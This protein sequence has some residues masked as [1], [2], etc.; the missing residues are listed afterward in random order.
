MAPSACVDFHPF[1]ETL[2]EWEKG[3]PVDCG[4]DWAWSTI[5]AAVEKG[6]HKSATTPESVA[7]IA[8]DVAYQ[9][10]AGYAQVITWAE[11]QRL[12]PPNLKVSPLA[13]V[14]QRNRRG[15]MILDLSFAVRRGRTRGRKRSLHDDIILQESVNDSTV[16][17]APKDP[18]KELGNVLPRLLDFMMD[19]PA[20]EHI[21]FSKMDLADGYW[22]MVVQPE[23]RWNFAYVMPSTPG[24]PTK[25]VIPSALQMGW[26]ESPAYFCATTESVR[27]VAQAWLDQGTHKPTHPM[28]TFTAPEKPARTQSSP[29][30]A[31][32]MSAVYVDDFILAAVKDASGKFLQRTARATLHA[33]HS[34]F[35][36]PSVTGMPDAKDPVSEK[37]LA[38]GDARWD[39]KKEIL[40]YW[41]DGINRTIQLPPPRA[42]DLLKEAKAVLKKKRV[43]LKRFRSLTGRL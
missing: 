6:A 9:V 16:R 31:H 12:R 35:P 8:E 34:V 42:I 2:R 22:R 21:H 40:G 25:L 24:S 3:V 39:T 18:V 28:E 23:A 30:P 19:V 15:R 41:L 27:D 17:L 37:K 20:E 1:V 26:N 38:K 5:E 4:K 43:P 29:G 11:L 13:V 33:I 10:K 7:L 14:P 36:P 32:Q